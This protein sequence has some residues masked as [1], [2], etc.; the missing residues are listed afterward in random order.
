MFC[1]LERRGSA[2]VGGGTV[3]QPRKCP[4]CGGGARLERG[5]PPPGHDTYHVVVC[6]KCGCRSRYCFDHDAAIAAWNCR[7]G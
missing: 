5:D 7:E 6:N 4:F 2:N 1:R 3:A